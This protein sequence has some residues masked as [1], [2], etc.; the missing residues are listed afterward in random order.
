M[1]N[2][3][4]LGD[5]MKQYEDAYRFK[6]SRRQPVIIRVDGRAFHTY[7]AKLPKPYSIKLMD[8]MDEVAK[9]L[10]KQVA[11]AVA[12]Y[13]QSDE[14]SLL[15]ID[16]QSRDTQAWFDNNLQKMVAVAASIASAKMTAL[17]P[18]LFGEVREATFDARAFIL[19]KEEVENY[20]IWRQQDWNR[21]SIQ[22]FARSLYS[23]K[24]LHGKNQLALQDLIRAKGYDW[25]LLPSHHRDG[26]FIM[27]LVDFK[28][29]NGQQVQTSVWQPLG[30]TPTFT[31]EYGRTVIRGLVEVSP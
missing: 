14:I 8:A 21:N 12:A 24:E 3:D 17:S 18:T 27:K 30:T 15:V 29:I 22:M 23:Q 9:A 2:A 16:Y 13:V 5:R 19:P 1:S 10:L 31:S 7:T 25:N 6:L 20:F 28:D 4:S 26:R 11:G